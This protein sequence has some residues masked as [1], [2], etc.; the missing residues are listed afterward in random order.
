MPCQNLRFCHG[1]PGKAGTGK[2]KGL[3]PCS[4]TFP[5]G[6]GFLLFDKSWF[7]EGAN[8]L[9][10]HLSF[11][12]IASNLGKIHLPLKGKAR[13]NARLQKPSPAPKAQFRGRW[14]RAALTDEVVTPQL[15]PDNSW[16]IKMTHQLP[17]RPCFPTCVG[18]YP[19]GWK[20][21]LPLAKL[22]ALCADGMARIKD[23]RRATPEGDRAP[24]P[25]RALMAAA[26][27]SKQETGYPSD[28]LRGPPPHSHG[29]AWV[30]HV[31]KSTNRHIEVLRQLPRRPCFPT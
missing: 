4:A 14:Q 11:P 15:S 18:K 3:P 9:R 19:S 6:E 26:S 22:S 13:R 12:Q 10:P 16:C 30:D 25:C 24:H 5:K 27:V 17:R 21:T 20:V 8:R 7:V 29:E 28:P 23:S 2:P 31:S 1:S